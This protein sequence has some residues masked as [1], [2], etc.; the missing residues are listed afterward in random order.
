VNRSASLLTLCAKRYPRGASEAVS[1][2][3]SIATPR[4]A[5]DQG[6]VGAQSNLGVAYFNGQGVAQ[7]YIIAHMWF[8]LAASRATDTATR[9]LVVKE[10]DLTAAKMT[11]DQIA[12]AQRLASEWKPK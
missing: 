11:P 5:A 8:I 4:K 9:E 3:G 1:C 12:K 2:W 10:R 7:D 6:N